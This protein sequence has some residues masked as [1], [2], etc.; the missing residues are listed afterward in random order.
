MKSQTEKGKIRAVY[1]SPKK[2][3]NLHNLK[4]MAKTV[5]SRIYK[6]GI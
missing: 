4:V 5:L 1:F 2:R 6:K 3:K